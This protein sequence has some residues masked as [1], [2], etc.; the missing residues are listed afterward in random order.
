LL[1]QRRPG[2]APSQLLALLEPAPGVV[3]ALERPRAIDAC[4]A[5]QR[6]TGHCACACAAASA[7]R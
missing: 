7:A 1:L 2:L 5:M 4:A 3:L 6:S